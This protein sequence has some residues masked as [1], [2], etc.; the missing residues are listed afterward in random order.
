M[1]ATWK[2][3]PVTRRCARPAI[4]GCFLWLPP[5]CPVAPGHQLHQY[6]VAVARGQGHSVQLGLHRPGGDRSATQPA[7]QR[8]GPGGQFLGREDVPQAEHPHR[9]RHVPVGDPGA[10]LSGGR[11]SGRLRRVLG[12]PGGDPAQQP[13]VGLVVQTGL[14]GT[15]VGLGG[16]ARLRDSLQ[17]GI[18]VG[19]DIGHDNGGCCGKLRH[20]GHPAVRH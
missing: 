13:V 2:P 16:R 20:G 12:L 18:L 17:I 5:P 1:T 7:L 6:P 8:G 3:Q 15:V 14:G 4:A 9:V 11:V 10:H 19:Q